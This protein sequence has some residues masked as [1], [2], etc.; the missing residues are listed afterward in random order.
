M[1]AQTLILL[2]CCKT[3]Q[4]YK[5]YLDDLRNTDNA[6]METVTMNFHD[7]TGETLGD[8]EFEVCNI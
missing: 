8:F 5:G 7:E 4:V 2:F 3:L 6:W 1:R